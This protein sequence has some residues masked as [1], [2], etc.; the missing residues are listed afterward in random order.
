M[1]T[2]T[3]APEPRLEWVSVAEYARRHASSTKTVYRH[4]AKGLIPGARQLAPHHP[5]RI[6]II[7]G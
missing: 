2:T 1:N 3:Q 5:Y 6:P 4:L 7:T